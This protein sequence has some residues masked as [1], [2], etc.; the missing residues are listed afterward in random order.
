MQCFTLTTVVTLSSIA[1]AL[2]S[3][4]AQ[5][6]TVLTSGTSN[7]ASLMAVRTQ[8]SVDTPEL[9]QTPHAKF[10]LQTEF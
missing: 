2:A 10:L 6:L 1:A 5:M 8:E 4:H 9:I 3:V 7:G